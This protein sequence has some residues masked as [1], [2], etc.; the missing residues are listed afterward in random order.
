MKRVVLARGSD[1]GDH[2]Q[3]AE[4]QL[5]MQRNV[6]EPDSVYRDATVIAVADRQRGGLS[7]LI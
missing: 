4:N 3:R 1:T 7:K 5:H 2:V 6:I